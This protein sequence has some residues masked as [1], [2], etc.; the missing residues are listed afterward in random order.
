MYLSKVVELDNPSITEAYQSTTNVENF[1][2][3]VDLLGLPRENMFTLEDL[4][5]GSWEQ[6][7]EVVTGLFRLQRLADRLGL[8]DP[9]NQ[10]RSGAVYDR[11]AYPNA[12]PS[13][14]A[15]GPN[16][17]NADGTPKGISKL[18]KETT[19]FLIDRN[20]QPGAGME[21]Q[22]IVLLFVS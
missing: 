11:Y 19:Q 13:K 17:P 5:G 14:G 16:P 12:V 10:P 22:V 21:N 18:L 6:Y 15:Y 1:L 2:D 4:Q 8:P 3:A 20:I 9:Q 7:P